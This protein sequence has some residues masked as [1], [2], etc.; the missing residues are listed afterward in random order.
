MI[1]LSFILLT[2]AVFSVYVLGV[3]KVV[4]GGDSGDIILA[5]YFGGVPH[6]PGYPLNT[7]LGFVLTKILP[8]ETFAYRAN[9]VSAIFQAV[10]VG[11]LYLFS[12]KLTRNWLI[13]LAG[14]L[15]LA[16]IPLFWLYVFYLHMARKP[17]FI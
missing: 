1:I 10:S 11:L 7:F 13:A 5:Y 8:G 15:T 12:Y 3:S 16:F 2:V 17:S 9:M 14:S 4:F 6:P